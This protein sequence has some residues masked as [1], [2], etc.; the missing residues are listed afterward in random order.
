[1]RPLREL[2]TR[3]IKP[4]LLILMSTVGMLL[5]IACANVANLLLARSAGSAARSGYA[6]PL[7]RAA[8]ACPAAARREP[9]HRL[10]GRNI[11]NSRRGL[12]HSTPAAML[13]RAST[14]TVPRASTISVDMTVLAFTTVVSIAAGLIFGLVPAMR[15]S[16]VDLNEALKDAARG[17]ASGLAWLPGRNALV[18]A[19]VAL[20][21]MLLAGAGLLLRSF[22]RLAGVE[23]GF[24]PHK[25]LTMTVPYAGSPLGAPERRADLYREITRRVS[26]LPGVE[27]AGAIN[28]IPI[29]GDDW[30]MG[31]VPEGQTFR[32]GEMPRGLYRVIRPNYFHTMQIPILAGRDITEQDDASAPHVAAITEASARQFW[33]TSDAC[34]QEIPKLI[35]RAL[36]DGGG[37]QRQRR[38]N[39]SET[40]ARRGVL[41][42]PSAGGDV[43][44]PERHPGRVLLARPGGPH[45]RRSD[46]DVGTDSP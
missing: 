37:R 8:S 4:M 31:F 16:R 40:A 38:S 17:S 22:L 15:A 10:C 11:G 42:P 5:L 45:Q 27:S 39:G 46:G 23:P 25:V 43:Y 13:E 6:W 20:S 44:G 1:M 30:H 19:E 29:G 14:F 35:R 21:L 28:H 36:D 34:G 33:G 2:T 3:N 9:G 18:I 7:V 32:A 41:R 26:S 12:G 24:N